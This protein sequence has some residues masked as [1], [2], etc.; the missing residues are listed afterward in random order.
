[1]YAHAMLPDRRHQLILRTLRADGPTTVTALSDV[2]GVSPATVRRDLLQLD[3]EGLLKRVYGGALAVADR[4]DPFVDVAAIRV[5]EKDAIA[6]RCGELI[7]DGETV[8]LDI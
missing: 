5:S 6:Q 8:L 7:Q 1:M 2:L 4:D 3:D